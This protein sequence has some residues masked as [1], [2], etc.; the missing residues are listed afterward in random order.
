MQRALR[1]T[2]ATESSVTAADLEAHAREWIARYKV[3]K[4]WTLQAEA[5]PLSAAGKFLKL[6]LRKRF[7]SEGRPSSSPGGTQ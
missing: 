1:A 4:T 3:P 2:S 6:E 5:L 7:E